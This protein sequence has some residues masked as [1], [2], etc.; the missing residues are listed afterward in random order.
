V[1]RLISL[2]PS[3]RLGSLREI[4]FAYSRGCNPTSYLL[5]E[6][7]PEW[8]G[9]RAKRVIIRPTPGAYRD[10]KESHP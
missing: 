7:D 3:F 8:R 1:H 5:R 9:V 6:A 4:R 10:R 2:A